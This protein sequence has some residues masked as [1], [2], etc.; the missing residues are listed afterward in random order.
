MCQPT[1]NLFSILLAV[2]L[3]APPEQP[4]STI[5]FTGDVLL[6]RGV[7]R[8]VQQVAARRHVSEA[9]AATCLFTPAVTALFRGSD[10]VVV[11]LEC[12]ATA[13]RQPVFKRFNFRAEPSWLDALR[14]N[15]VT[16]CNLGNN[17]AIDQGRQGLLSTL[18]N[19][20][21]HGMV[22]VGAGRTLDEA[23]LPVLLVERPRKVFLLASAQMDLENFPFLP[24]KPSVS[25]MRV[26]TLCQRI[27]QLKRQHRGCAVV[28][29]LHWGVEHTAAPTPQQRQQARRLIDA[30]ADALV[31]HHTHTW[32]GEES[33]RG[34]P[35]FYS[36]GNFIFDPSRPLNQRGAIVQLIVS[37]HDVSAH[38]LPYD[39]R[40]CVPHL[41][42]AA[43]H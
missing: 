6:D 27:R 15:G 38:T 18:S 19:V 13:I 12:P 5:T 34:R 21:Q 41:L 35:I 43:I 2:S 40:H 10:A 8:H 4:P 1:M 37:Q 25:Q 14:R 36:L 11:N 23:T 32:Q 28:V 17:H 9:E 42:P 30:G 16:H 22:P 26:D 3:L 29:S 7:R 31:C 24:A 39:I 33:Y 20:R